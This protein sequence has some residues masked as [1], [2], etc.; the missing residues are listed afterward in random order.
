[1]AERFAL[2]NELQTDL[3]VSEEKIFHELKLQPKKLQPVGVFLKIVNDIPPND[4]PSIR[5]QACEEVRED[6]KDLEQEIRREVAGK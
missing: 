1:M 5:Q 2:L 4:R 6:L 3:S